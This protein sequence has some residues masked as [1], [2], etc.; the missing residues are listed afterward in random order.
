MANYSKT[1]L[2]AKFLAT[3]KVAWHPFLYTTN[4]AHE[5]NQKDPIK[6]NRPPKKE[7]KC[8]TQDGK[9]VENS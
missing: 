5:N 7:E 6:Y 8:L 2:E 1:L 4:T 3:A 9:E